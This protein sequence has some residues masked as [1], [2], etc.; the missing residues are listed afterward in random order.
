[1]ADLRDWFAGAGFASVRTYLQSGNVVVRSERPA[2]ELAQFTHRLIAERAGRSLPVVV[3]TRLQLRQ[4]LARDPFDAESVAEKLYQVTFLASDAPK[5]LSRE[6]AGLAAGDERFVAHRREWYTYHASGI[7][8][9]KLA[10]RISAR[11]LGL[12]ATTRN[13]VT[14]RNLLALADEVADGP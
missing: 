10:S 12:T 13:W 7:A 9:S 14:V 2:A 11:N 1:M 3:R 6:L 8:R 4:V 5:E